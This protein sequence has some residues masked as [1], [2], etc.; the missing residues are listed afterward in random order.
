[1]KNF[2]FLS[3]LPRSG[4]TL[5]S[6]ILN[7]NPDIY[8]GPNSPMCGMMFNL[9][10]SILASEQY[11]AYAKPEVMPSTIMGVLHNYY[12]DRTESIILDKSREWAIQEH[13]NVLLR[14]M[15][16]DPKVVLTVRNITDILASF[17]YM[18][19][20][21][22]QSLSFI[23]QEIQARQ[24]FNFYRPIDDIRC[25]HLMRPK[26]L[27][28][29]ALYGIAF[30]GLEENK[31]YFHIIEYEDLVNNTKKTI[32]GVYEFLGLESY[33]HDFT[34]IINVVP[35]DDRVYGLRGLH[36]VRSEISRR[37]I[38][39]EEILSPYVL[40]KYSGLEFWREVE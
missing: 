33:N 20:Q 35:E 22:P 21:N 29:N 37:E 16:E 25:D 5:L 24:E 14:N 1:M 8:S 4:S 26:G 7:Q 15:N 2:H 11:R 10:Q 12:L 31:E 13:F 34:N 19:Y 32:D 38:K 30:S 6:S 28:D 18:I 39:K 40:N 23:D 17:I 9:E 3:G 27:I 36:H